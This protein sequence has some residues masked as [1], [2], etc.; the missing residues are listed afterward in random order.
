[1]ATDPKATASSR[2]LFE[3]GTMG[4]ELYSGGL[5]GRLDQGFGEGTVGV[6]GA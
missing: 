4:I 1:M 2:R 3:T 6:R 5:V